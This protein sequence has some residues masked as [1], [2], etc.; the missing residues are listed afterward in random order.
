MFSSPLGDGKAGEILVG[1]MVAKWITIEWCQG[2]QLPV[3]EVGLRY[4]A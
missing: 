2:E 1:D 3:L 4:V